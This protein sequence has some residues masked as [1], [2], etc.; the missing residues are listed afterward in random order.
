MRAAAVRYP[1]AVLEAAGVPPVVRDEAAEELFPDDRYDLI[2]ASF[3]DLGADLAEVGLYWG[4]AKAFEH[5]RRHQ[6][7]PPGGRR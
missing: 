3:A 6:P 7:N 1:T 2:P 4:A 5:K